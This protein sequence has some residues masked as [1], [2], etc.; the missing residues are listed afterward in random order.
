MTPEEKQ[1]LLLQELCMRLQY[2]PYIEVTECEK[3]TK[4]NRKLY[5]SAFWS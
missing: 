2:K 4:K 3:I 1:I 5:R